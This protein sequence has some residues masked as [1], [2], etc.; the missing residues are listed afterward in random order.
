MPVTSAKNAESV[1][2][3]EGVSENRWVFRPTDISK[4]RK[5]RWVVDENAAIVVRRIYN[6]TLD[7]LGT[8]Q[9]AAALSNDRILTPI[10]YWR[11][12]GVNRDGKASEERPPYKWNVSSVSK[13]LSLQEY[14]GDVINFKTYSKSYKNKKRLPNS[15]ENRMIFKN[16]HEPIIERSVWE[17]VQQQR[18]KIRKRRTNEGEKNMFS[19]LLVC[20]DCGHNLWY[21]FSQ[22]NPDIKFFNCANYKGNRGTCASTHYIRV[23]FL[24]QVVLGEIRRLTRFASRFEAEFIRA[25]QGFSQDAFLSEQKRKQKELREMNQRDQELDDLF[26]RMYEDNVA[27]RI[28]DDRFAKMSGRYELEQG[29]LSVRIKAL[30]AELEKETSKTITTNS[31]VSSVQK[32]TRA[33]KLTQRM[34]NELIDHI[35]VHQ[36]EKID[37]KFVQKLVVHYNCVGS[38]EIPDI[39]PLSEPEVEIQTRKGV[40]IRYS[41]ES[42]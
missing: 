39:L 19:G 26:E 35:E 22:K 24:E 28:S 27:G 42:A 41:Q 18:G 37:G 31:F 13:I 16:V 4:I 14:C 33:R 32:Y 7:G 25:M 8:E 40:V 15:E 2:K 12:K 20:A 3:S 36:A 29:E 5:M 9:I 10:F 34:L 11:S 1:T 17:R 38:I 30:R 23:D 21:H 6:L